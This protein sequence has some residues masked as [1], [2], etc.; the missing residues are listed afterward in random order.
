MIAVT[1][2]QKQNDINF[3]CYARIYVV[4][5]IKLGRDNNKPRASVVCCR[6]WYFPIITVWETLNY[7]TIGTQSGNISCE[8]HKNLI[9]IRSFVWGRLKGRGKGRWYLGQHKRHLWM[10]SVLRSLLP[11]SYDKSSSSSS[12]PHFKPFSFPSIVCREWSSSFAGIIVSC[13]RLRKCAEI[14]GSS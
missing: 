2:E 7:F 8:N 12:P 5:T 10:C 4:S 14:F 6:R 3:S 1:S 13:R 9:F 11:F